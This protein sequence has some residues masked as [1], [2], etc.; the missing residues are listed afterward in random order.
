MFSVIAVIII[1]IIIIIFFFIIRVN[2]ST[3]I[4]IMSVDPLNKRIRSFEDAS[5]QKMSNDKHV[6]S[7]YVA[8]FLRTL[9]WM[10]ED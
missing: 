8:T 1:I 10:E 9:K 7:F 2:E 5:L 3:C 6:V 4:Y